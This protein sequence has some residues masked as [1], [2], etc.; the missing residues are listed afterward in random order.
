LINDTSL[1]QFVHSPTRLNNLLDIVFCAYPKINNLSTVPGISDHDA[2]TFHFDIKKLST[3]SVKQHKVLLYHRENTE[4]I[5]QDLAAL[6]D[7]FQSSDPQT[8]SVEQLWQE[9][10][11][12]VQKA[13]SKHVPHKVKHSRNSLPWINKERH[14]KA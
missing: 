11:Q 7:N 8:R 6:A 10:K 1:E 2:I 14:E 5:K 9:F 4:L 3:S 13:V 12:A